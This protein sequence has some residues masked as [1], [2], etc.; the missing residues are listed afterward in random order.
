MPDP[1]PP[2]DREA[3]KQAVRAKLRSIELSYVRFR[4]DV[5]V[6]IG[7]SE[8]E[9][10]WR[11]FV[12]RGNSVLSDTA[13]FLEEDVFGNTE[14]VFRRRV[15]AQPGRIDKPHHVPLSAIASY[16]LMAD[17]P[18]ALA[19][20]KLAASERLARALVEKTAQ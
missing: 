11:A 4:K 18:N 16:S 20:S 5:S 2:P 14:V 6:A 13:A 19:E 8:V 15:D 10:S 3:T 17:E 7:T 12:E 1:A 9:G